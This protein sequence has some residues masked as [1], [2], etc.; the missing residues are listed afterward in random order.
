MRSV[1]DQHAVC[2]RGRRENPMPLH[3]QLERLSAF[4]TAPYPVISLYLNTQPNERGRDQYQAFVRKEFKARAQTYAPN[5]PERASLD[6][7]FERIGRYLETELQPSANGVAI[8]ACDAGELFEA[9]QLDAPL[10]DH[11]LYIGDRPHLYPLA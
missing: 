7:D 6:R 10:D 11:W 2:V 8:F 1:R 4:E 9:V 3:D 5:S